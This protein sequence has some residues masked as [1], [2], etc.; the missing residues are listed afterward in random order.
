[1]NT[2]LPDRLFA[3]AV[4]ILMACAWSAVPDI[5]HP[6]GSDWGH[7]FTA[8]EFIWNPV[9]GLAYPDFRK[10]WFGWLMGGVG[11]GMGYLAAAQMIGK[12]SLAGMVLGAALLGASMASR[13]VGLVAGGTV[14]LMPLAM[15]GALWVNHYPAL[16]AAVG[17]AFGAGAAAMRWRWTGWVILAGIAAGIAWALD[18]RGL[19]ALP[20]AAGLVLLGGLR[21][22]LK[23]CIL[24][25]AVFGAVF[26][27]PFAQDVWLQRTFSI[28]QLEVASQ[29]AVQRKGTLEQIGQG[30]VGG[31]R[32]RQACSGQRVERFR[33]ASAGTECATALRTSSIERLAALGLIPSGIVLT[34]GAFWLLP[35][36][37]RR[38]WTVALAGAG[39]V[40]APMLSL[41]MGMG[42]VTYFD[43][44]VLPFAV[45]IAALLPVAAG[46]V[47]DLVPVRWLRDPLGGVLALGATALVWPGLSARNI[48]AP[49][50]VQSSEYH[51]GVFAEWASASL[52]PADGVIDC[53]GLA[54]DSL[55]LPRRID[56]VRYPPGDPECVALI[57]APT[58]RSGQTFLITMHRDLPPNSS[59]T[60]L[61]YGV[62][63]IAAQGWVEAKHTLDVDGYR[64]WVRP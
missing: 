37:P 1:M 36:A 9:D 49:E 28:P 62:S 64:L 26:S 58:R 15:D 8:A 42:W 30:L 63:A 60:D 34:A 6:L 13:W 4:V 54:V 16:G 33:V 27:G 44:Y 21:F 19:I 22:G 23:S 53:A 43:R 59:P 57:K 29:L 7:Y 46:R 51:A 39:I 3:A 24:R 2:D 48:D 11:Q 25:L 38:R 47:A 35:S 61:P 5:G 50:R 31:D 52:G 10:P 55:L 32:V 41:Y 56:Y 40:G 14:I 45:I 18:F 20:A 17:L 12:I